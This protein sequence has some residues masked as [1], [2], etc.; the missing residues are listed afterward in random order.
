MTLSPVGR[1]TAIRS[2]N[3]R[4]FSLPGNAQIGHLQRREIGGK[5]RIP[6]S[7]PTRT[8]PPGETRI[9]PGVHGNVPMR[10]DPVRVGSWENQ[11]MKRAFS[12]T[13]WREGDW[14]IA[15]CL[16]VDVASQGKTEGEALANL[17]EALELHFE[18]P[19]ATNPPVVRRIEVEV[20]AA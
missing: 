9:Y 11:R 10:A 14:I 6:T 5:F 13:T 7:R 15:Q 20:G 18:P 19:V 17:R 16:E 12:A 3:G 8:L 4:I 1:Y 2:N